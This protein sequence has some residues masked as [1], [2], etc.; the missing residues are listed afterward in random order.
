MVD[1]GHERRLQAD[2]SHPTRLS[3]MATLRAANGHS[4][5]FQTLRRLA[6]VSESNL[7]KVVSKLEA[8]G[9]ISVVKARE[10]G[11]RYTTISMTTFGIESFDSH[12]SALI[13]SIA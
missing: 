1:N 9:Y 3:I 6:D 10:D 8:L 2:L 11:R 7:S 12:V 13:A 5:A 4:L